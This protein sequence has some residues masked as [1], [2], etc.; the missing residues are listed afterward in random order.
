M[1]LAEGDCLLLVRSSPVK[2]VSGETDNG[3]VS[4]AKTQCAGTVTLCGDSFLSKTG[5]LN[6]VRPGLVKTKLQKVNPLGKYE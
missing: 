6:D 1:V 4:S 3:A 5:T 2:E